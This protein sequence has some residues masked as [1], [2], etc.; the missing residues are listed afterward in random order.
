M[1]YLYYAIMV[2][3]FPVIFMEIRK[4]K[5]LQACNKFTSL[6]GILM[7]WEW[8][9]TYERGFIVFKEF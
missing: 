3:R 9:T 5:L 7:K 2:R 6:R 8:E 1:N 4:K